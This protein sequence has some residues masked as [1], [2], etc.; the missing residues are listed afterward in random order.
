VEGR[1][2]SLV[3]PLAGWASKQLIRVPR[4][5]DRSPAATLPPSWLSMPGL[6]SVA[7]EG[8]NSKRLDEEPHRHPCWRAARA[9]APEIGAGLHVKATLPISDGSRGD[10]PSIGL[11]R[12]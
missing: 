8:R 12:G 7:T 6:R 10:G 9:L 4:G 1:A 3:A 2:A 11:G 5:D